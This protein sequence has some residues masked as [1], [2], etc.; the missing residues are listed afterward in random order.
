MHPPHQRLRPGEG[1]VVQPVLGLEVKGKLSLGQRGLHGVGNGLLPQEL[2]PQGIVINGKVL[3]IVALNAV[4]R[5]H[6]PVAHLL[7]GNGAVNNLVNAPF[8]HHALRFGQVI[9]M[10]LLHKG[11]AVMERAVPFLQAYEPVRIEMTEDSLFSDQLP[12]RVRN[13]LQQPVACLHAE[14][15]VIQLEI[16]HVGA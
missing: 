2:F 8:H 1:A 15:I 6:G 9:L 12:Q 11:H 5:Q 7:H 14:D 3:M 16:L 13:V 10:H 4:H